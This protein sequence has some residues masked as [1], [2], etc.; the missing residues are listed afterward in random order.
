MLK[1]INNFF[2]FFRVKGMGNRNQKKKIQFE[3]ENKFVGIRQINEGINVL[4]DINTLKSIDRLKTR[5]KDE[6]REGIELIGL[7][8]LEAYYPEIYKD[9]YKIML[10][11]G[12]E[13]GV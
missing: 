6:I 8:Y 7:Y 12:K 3:K 5:Y 11:G 2:G 10:K 1:N 4:N 9:I 13:N